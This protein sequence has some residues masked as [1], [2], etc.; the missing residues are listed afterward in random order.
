MVEVK[1]INAPSDIPAE[2]SYVFV[3][4]WTENIREAEL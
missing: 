2:G 3:L 1:R 4:R